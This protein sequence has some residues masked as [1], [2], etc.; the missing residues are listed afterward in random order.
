[1]DRRA[2]MRPDE[3]TKDLE[4]LSSRYAPSANHLDG[5]RLYKLLFKR[6]LDLD[7]RF[8]IVADSY[9]EERVLSEMFW[10]EMSH[11]MVELVGKSGGRPSSVCLSL[12]LYGRSIVVYHAAYDE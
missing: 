10:D 2:G 5:R 11:A 3:I 6:M 12:W 8:Y 7:N 1:M 9:Q 4:Y